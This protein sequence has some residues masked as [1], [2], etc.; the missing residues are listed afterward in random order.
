MRAQAW[1]AIQ[2][3]GASSF[4]PE[5]FI[6]WMTAQWVIHGWCDEY[7]QHLLSVCE[8]RGLDPE[9]FVWLT[10]EERQEAARRRDVA[11]DHWSVSD[12]VFLERL[13]NERERRTRGL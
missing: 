10:P 9:S 5:E 4:A 8:E 12:E 11:V 3:A 7:A 1:Q 2:D 13:R 6:R